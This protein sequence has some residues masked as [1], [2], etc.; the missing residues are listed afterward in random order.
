MRTFRLSLSPRYRSPATTF[1]R[2]DGR[3]LNNSDPIWRRI[4]SHCRRLVETAAEILP[5]SLGNGFLHRWHPLFVCIKVFGAD[6]GHRDADR[7]R[8]RVRSR[9]GARAATLDPTL[10][11]SRWPGI[12]FC[13]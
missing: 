2:L 1:G 6:F 4:A 5:T 3:V 13:Y 12:G 7:R 10:L 11:R 8:L 9:V